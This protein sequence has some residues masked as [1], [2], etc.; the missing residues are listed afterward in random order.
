M[1][2]GV[3]DRQQIALRRMRG[4]VDQ[5][6][7]APEGI[8]RP[9]DNALERRRVLVRGGEAEPAQRLAQR[10]ALAGGGRDGDLSALRRE[11]LGNASAKAGAGGGDEGDFVGHVLLQWKSRAYHWA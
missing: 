8:E 9:G 1:P 4:G 5:R 11:L 2:V 10:L 3:R 6:I 7:D